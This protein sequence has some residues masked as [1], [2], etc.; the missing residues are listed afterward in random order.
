MRK[1]VDLERLKIELPHAEGGEFRGKRGRIT[2]D[3]LKLP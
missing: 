2:N 3:P 1:T